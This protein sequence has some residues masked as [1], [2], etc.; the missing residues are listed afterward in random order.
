MAGDGVL[1]GDVQLADYPNDQQAKGVWTHDHSM[2]DTSYNVMAGLAGAYLIR[3]DEEEALR[4]PRGR[5]EVALLLCDR[6][7]DIG[8]SG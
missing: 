6:N 7:F 2:N 5:Y 3:D 4:F 1:P 8:D